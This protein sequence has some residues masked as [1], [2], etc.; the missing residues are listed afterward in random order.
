MIQ[1]NNQDIFYTQ[2]QISYTVMQRLNFIQ[3]VDSNGLILKISIQKNRNSNSSIRCVLEIDF[4]YPK[5]LCELHNNFLLVPGTIEI[6]K[7]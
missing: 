5:E 7:C 1:N 3:Q 6:K 4:E 2:A